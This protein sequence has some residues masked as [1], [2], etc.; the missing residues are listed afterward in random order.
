MVV[1][2]E[3][4]ERWL[5]AILLFALAFALWSPNAFGQT[6]NNTQAEMKY[7]LR[8]M[9]AELQT[10]Y[11]P[12]TALVRII[13]TSHRAV[14]LLLGSF[15]AL[16]SDTIICSQGKTQ[17]SIA[18]SSPFTPIRGGV[19]GVSRRIE[20]NQGGGDVGFIEISPSQIGK[21]GEGVIPN[22]YAVRSNQLFLGTAP[23]GSDTLFVYFSPVTPLLDAVT[24][25]LTIAQEDQPAM[26][27][28]ALSM[29]YGRD[30]QVQ[31]AQMYWQM[32]QAMIAAKKP[33]PSQPQG[34]T[35]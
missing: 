20:T 24:D 29:I 33:A 1:I 14:A 27:F 11:L 13:N 2:K 5:M 22:S 15:T 35:P 6:M 9:S 4:W 3:N 32:A 30:H 26:I 17:Y 31:L 25:T 16:E 12:D 10:T 34:I 23:T 7:L 21:L 28:M 8:D 19:S 18:P